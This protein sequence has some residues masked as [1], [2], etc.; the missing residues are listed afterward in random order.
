MANNQGKFIPYKQQL[1]EEA[2]MI[3]RSE[4]Y[5]QFM[6][7]RRSVREFSDKEEPN[8]QVPFLFDAIKSK[9]PSKI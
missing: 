4:D 8:R 1:F 9:M 6:D 2:E 7:K 3:E 5:F